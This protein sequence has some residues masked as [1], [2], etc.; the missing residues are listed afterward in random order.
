MKKIFYS[1]LL[2]LANMT[3][4]ANVTPDV[5]GTILDVDGKPMPCVNVVLLSMPDSTFIQGATSDDEGRFHVVTPAEQGLL[6]VSCIGYETL[7]IK[8]SDFKGTIQMKND[9]QILKE[10]TVKGQLPKTKLTGNSMITSIEGTVLEKSGTA[11]EML[12]KVPGMTQNGDDLEVLGKGAPLFYINGRKITDKDELMRLRSEEIKSVE[13][14]NNPGAQYDATVKSVVRIRTKKLQGTGFGYDINLTDNNDLRYG[15]NDPNATINLRY[16]HKSLDVFG[17]VNYWKWDNVNDSHPEQFS[18]VRID[19]GD[20]LNINQES[21]LRNDMNNQGINSNV[22]FNWQIADNHS[23]GMR[24]EHH[25]KFNSGSTLFIGTNMTQWLNDDESKKSSEYNESAQR[26]NN[27]R[28]YNWEGN[29]YY[30]GSIGKVGIDL[31]VDFYTLKETEDNNIEEENKNVFSKMRTLN[32]TSSHMIADKLV[33]S[34]PIWKGQLELGTEM[35]FVTRRSEYSIENLNKSQM[36]GNGIVIPTTNSEVNEDNVAGFIQYGFMVPK[37]GMFNAGI[38]YEHV[39]FKYN[40]LLEGK[41]SMSR[42]TNEFYPS[43]SWANQW[44]AWQ[45]SLSYSLKTERPNYYM[46]NESMIYINPYSLQQGNPKL[47]NSKSMEFGAN[48]HWKFLNLYMNYERCKDAMTQWSYIYNDVTNATNS[49]NN[50]VVLIKFINLENPIHCFSTYLSANPIWGCYSP[51]WTTGFQKVSYEQILADPLEATGQRI[52]EYKKP[53]FIANF[54]NAFRFKH[55]W[56]VECNLNYTSKGDYM[57][58]RLTGSTTNLNFVVQKCWLK[59][60]A[61]CLRASVSDVLNRTCQKLE[62]DC[63]YYTLHQKMYN[64]RQ[65]LYVSLRYTFNASQSKYKGTGAGKDA[66]ERMK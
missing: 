35:T 54:N 63:G 38:R 15:Y 21:G 62:L 17:S 32:P 58:F 16:R 9:E 66:V 19:N 24:I 46:L 44:G 57:N 2:S 39:G 7:Y 29:T 4:M 26:G 36:I 42:Y 61:L 49:T 30:N 13:V 31:N 48:I 25:S 10:V 53:I 20:I 6:K 47:K 50:G 5:V 60:D 23:V 18:H 40:D 1:A 65:R 8:T 52:V 56:Q 55:S 14:I 12:A 37:A 41:N 11:K 22:G 59:N 64:N 51:N 34:Y 28:D 27:E 3:A 43:L 45:T 33:F